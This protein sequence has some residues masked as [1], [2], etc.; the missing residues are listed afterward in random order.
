[1]SHADK[2]GERM[3]LSDS[4]NRMLAIEDE[5][6]VHESA[7]LD[8]RK[9]GQEIVAQFDSWRTNLPFGLPA[10]AA[11]GKASKAEGKDDLKVG[12]K[13][14]LKRAIAKAHADGC[15]KEVALT[16]ADAAARRFCEKK[17]VV[18]LPNWVGPWTAQTVDKTFPQ[19]QAEAPVADAIE[20]K[21]IEPSQA[22]AP[23]ATKK[24]KK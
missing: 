16:S 7:I 18:E 10:I 20:T 9:E 12:L 5:V 13:L 19:L 3:N 21:E 15:A 2:D 17:G 1:M 6:K 14:A 23:K 4:I 24:R 22:A 8:L 11:K